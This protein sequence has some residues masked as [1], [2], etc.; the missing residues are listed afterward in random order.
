MFSGSRI[1]SP[2]DTTLLA[3]TVH[4][5]ETTWQNIPGA[6]SQINSPAD[7]T[8]LVS[9]VVSL[10]RNHLAKYPRCMKNSQTSLEQDCGELVGQLPS[11]VMWLL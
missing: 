9:T 7:T 2:A 10:E 1:N 6:G 3:S 5:R 4:W 8:L 11:H